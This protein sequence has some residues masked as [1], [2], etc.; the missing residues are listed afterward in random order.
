MSSWWL[1]LSQDKNILLPVMWQMQMPLRLANFEPEICL[2]AAGDL[3][4]IMRSQDPRPNGNQ[5]YTD[6]CK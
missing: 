3:E 2:K 4:P 5:N 6:E 1:S